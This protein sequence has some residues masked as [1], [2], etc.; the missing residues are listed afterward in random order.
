M[1]F[2]LEIY[3]NPCFRDLLAG[4]M[5]SSCWK[6][7]PRHLLLRGHFYC[8]PEAKKNNIPLA[9]TPGIPKPP[10][11]RNSFINRWLGVWGMFQGYVGKFL[12]NTSLLQINGLEDDLSFGARLGLFLRLAN[13]VG[14]PG[15]EVL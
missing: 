10:N 2:D 14:C 1:K 8:L 5:S 12:D 15:T 7:I 11:E 4:L 3:G 6:N 9:H 13:C